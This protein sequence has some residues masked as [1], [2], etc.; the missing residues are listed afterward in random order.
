MVA[1]VPSGVEA[2]DGRIMGEAVKADLTVTLGLAKRVIASDEIWEVKP[3]ILVSPFFT[4]GGLKADGFDYSSLVREIFLKET[5][6]T[7][8]QR[9]S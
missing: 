2:S 1:D 4:R 8:Y 9:E 7:K 6:T 3:W 5:Y